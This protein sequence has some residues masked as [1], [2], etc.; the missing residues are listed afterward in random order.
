MVSLL[1]VASERE[2]VRNLYGLH[3]K[4]ISEDRDEETTQISSPTLYIII[5]QMSQTSSRPYVN[6]FSK[7]YLN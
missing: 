1:Y 4:L 3:K 2:K 5:F 6:L 7:A